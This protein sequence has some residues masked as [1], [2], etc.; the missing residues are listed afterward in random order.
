VICDAE[1]TRLWN[2]DATMRL[3]VGDP[4]T[5]ADL[6]QAMQ[7][8]HVR[9]N[10]ARFRG[11]ASTELDEWV[12]VKNLGGAPQ[13]MGRWSVRVEGT[14]FRWTFADGFVLEPGQ[15]CK[16]YTG[17]AMAEPCGGSSDIAPMGVLPNEGGLLTLWV[18]FLDLKAIE[19]R[20]AADPTRQPP[21]PNLQGFN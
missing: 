16:F 12:E 7:W 20:Y 2:G 8:A 6:A 9:I 1:R 4:A 17:A 11:R 15:A 10:A 13:D 19:V 3:A 18:D 21:P 5:L 14:P